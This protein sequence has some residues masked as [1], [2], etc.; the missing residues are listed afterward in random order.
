MVAIE[1]LRRYGTDD[2]VFFYN[3]KV[4]VDF[5]IPDQ[6]LAIQVS[7]NPH[8]TLDTWTRETNALCKLAARLECRRL[9]ILT[10]AEENVV[11]I[12]GHSIEVVPLWKWLLE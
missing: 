1:L 4:E 9:L 3:K 7:Y 11:E 10:V 5:Y 2:R 12:N 8:A 6:A